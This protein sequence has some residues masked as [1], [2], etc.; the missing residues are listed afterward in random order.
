MSSASSW[1]ASSWLASTWLAWSWLASGALI[2]LGCGTAESLPAPVAEPVAVERVGGE[3]A[4]AV[5]SGNAAEAAGDD[6][7]CCAAAAAVAVVDT[8]G[9][10][11][12]VPQDPVHPRSQDPVRPG[13]GSEAFLVGAFPP[14]VPDTRWHQ[15]AW[16]QN[17]CLRCHETGVGDA[18]ELEH[19]G[20]PPVLLT[21]ACRTCH[22]FVPGSQ[23]RPRPPRAEDGR[24][25]PNA[26]PPLIPGSEYHRAA[27]L[28]N[29]CLL[30]H[31]NRIKGA[32]AV[33]HDGMP[34]VLLEAR[35]R[36]CH[37]QVRVVELTDR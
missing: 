25:E 3:P 14:T 6:A 24:F 36:S 26:F 15:D 4:V 1:L 22:V 17:D 30:C 21:A 2:A 10:R 29:D 5:D 20:L 28:R 37:V 23:P 13:A 34:P 12:I 11:P 7:G 27:W 35:C 9:E 19:R 31:E 18:P 33:R 32:P 8:L 16:A